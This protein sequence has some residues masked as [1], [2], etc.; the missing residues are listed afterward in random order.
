MKRWAF[1][2]L[3]FFA[4][5]Q[6]WA[7]IRTTAEETFVQA[8]EIVYDRDLGVVTAVGQVE[9]A[10]GGRVLRA[11]SVAYNQKAD[12]VVATGNVSLL[13]TTGDVLFAEFFDLD[14]ALKNGFTEHVRILMRDNARFAAREGRR[15]DGN[16][17]VLRRAVYSPCEICRDN[18]RRPLVWQVKADS[19]VHD[20]QDRMI[21]YRNAI[22]EVFDVPVA[23]LP[24][25]THPDPTVRRKSGFT[26]PDYSHSSVLGYRVDIPY[27][28]ELGPDKDVTVKP[29]YTTKEGPVG[30]LQYRQVLDRGQM[31]VAGSVTEVAQ[32][33]DRNEA[34]GGRETRGHVIGKGFNDVNATDRIGFR[35]ER[36][37]DDTYLRRYAFSSESTLVSRAY[38]ERLDGR[39]YM[40]A[41]AYAFQSLRSDDDPGLSPLVAPMLDYVKVGDPD[42]YGARTGLSAGAVALSR[43]DGRDTR[44]ASTTLD[45]QLPYISE[46]GEVHTLRASLRGDA[47]HVSGGQRIK[48]QTANEPDGAI[49]RL[50]PELHYDWRL[51]MVRAEGSTRQVVEPIGQL[52]ASPNGRNTRKIPNEDSVSFEFDDTSIFSANRFPGV[53]R[54]EGGTRANYGLKGSVYGESGGY[55]SVLIGQSYRLQDDGTFAHG[56]GLERNRS[57]LVG[58]LRVVPDDRLHLTHRI[59]V[60]R[61]NGEIRR[62][63]SYLTVGPKDYRVYLGYVSLEKDLQ[64]SGL[65]AREEFFASAQARIAEY[66]K[67]TAQTRQDLQNDRAV[68][69]GVSFVYTDEC[70]T[71]SFGVARD[72]TRDR[73]VVPG[74]TVSFR[75][76]LKNLG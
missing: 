5:E 13:E 10:Q 32:R 14:L 69:N 53:D 1:A 60:D 59:R 23:Y 15:E 54:I 25:L 71:L 45:W 21:E 61:D 39:S 27:F 52:I 30:Y 26:T 2:L 46:V 48:G 58:A 73:D 41:N 44:R 65:D 64:T 19:I 28:V 3:A 63:E 8:D 49:G 51:P 75:I 38:A 40:A 16:R 11:D 18:P 66:W 74:T 42:R 22:L 62:N 47:Y 57:D 35:V 56:T 20:E 17:L 31:E 36:A 72:F 43:M 33:N 68:K 55:S 67:I 9:I 76:K 12:R 70:V 29:I 7:Q 24:F 4:V 50:V 34:I 6:A 37:T